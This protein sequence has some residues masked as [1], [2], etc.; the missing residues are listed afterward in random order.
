MLIVN[1]RCHWVAPTKRDGRE[2]FDERFQ[3]HVRNDV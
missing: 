1:G 3:D 2:V